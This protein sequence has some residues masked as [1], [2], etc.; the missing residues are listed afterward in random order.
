MRERHAMRDGIG[1]ETR[2]RTLL[3]AGDRAAFERL[4]RQHNG[5]MIRVCTA[6]VGNRAAAEEVVQD[7]W[8]AILQNIGGFEGRAS[9]AGWMFA[10]VL[11]KAK[12]RA[13]R[14]G[15]SVSFDAGGEENSLAAAFDGR[16]RWKDMPEL[17]DEVTPE[18]IL[19]GRRV[20][21]H[22]TAAIEA[23]PP[24]QRAVI[25]LRGQQGLDAAE[26]CAALGISEGNMRVLLHRARLAVRAALDDLL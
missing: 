1:D 6:I 22:V 9:L 20:L 3:A 19:A 23:L 11:N 2:L 4:Y 17:W 10:I 21:D 26:V 25:V 7:G 15:R 14:D 13:R 16:G 24:A 8:I 18:R 5:A 12:S